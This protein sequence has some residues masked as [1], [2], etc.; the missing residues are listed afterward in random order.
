[1]KYQKIDG[2]G[3]L[4]TDS[5][6]RIDDQDYSEQI[7]K[8]LQ[9]AEGG[10]LRTHYKGQQIVVESFD[11]PLIIQH[12]QKFADRLIGQ[13]NYKLK[14]DLQLNSLSIDDWDRFHCQT[15]SGIPCVLSRHAQIEF[16][17]LLEEFDDESVTLSGHTYATPFWL[18]ERED[19]AHPP[20]WS[21]KYAKQSTPWDLGEYHPAFRTILEQTKPLR[22]RVAVLGC[23]VGHDAAFLAQS[24][25][26][27]TAFD[28]SEEAIKAARTKYGHI[29]HLEFVVADAFALPDKYLGQFDLV[30]EHTFFCAV[31]PQMRNQVIQ[32]YRNLL[33]AGGHL[34]AVMFV[35]PKFSG[36]PYGG[37][38]YELKRRF[39]HAFDLR[40]WT[41]HRTHESWRNGCELLIYA[42]KKELTHV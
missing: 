24:G 17:D 11:S 3:F 28:F 10:S 2:D 8:N 4:M 13:T 39:E 32:L 30:A 16:F 25:H 42:Q 23:G 26:F 1:M 35:M 7:L 21:D 41:R 40:Y 36:P 5:G 6:L 34:M 27:V 22:S 14:F 38:E 12:V 33:V 9:L 19:I 20:F 15:S 37:S 18:I 31:K 29:A